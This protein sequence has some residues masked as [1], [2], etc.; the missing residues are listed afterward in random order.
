M[1]IM[2]YGKQLSSQSNTIFL[3]FLPEFYQPDVGV[4][5]SEA[6]RG[7]DWPLQMTLINND[8]KTS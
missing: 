8:G 2:P 1:K 5:L 6:I 7:S 3:G 4:C